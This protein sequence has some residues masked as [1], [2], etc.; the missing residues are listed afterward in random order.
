MAG[1]DQT[2]FRRLLGRF[3]TGVTVVTTQVGREVHG[4]TANAFTS[5]SLE[6]PLVLICVD[7]RAHMLELLRQSGAYC[8][9]FLGEHQAGVSDYFAKRPVP[10][11]EE[12]FLPW[13]CGPRLSSALASLA[14]RVESHHEAGDH[15]LFVG[16]V[17][18]LHE[19][20]GTAR[21]L[22]FFG[23]SYGDFHRRGVPGAA[24]SVPLG[25]ADQP[26][27]FDPG[28]VP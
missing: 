19:G 7:R 11:P 1:V 27:F 24:E 2:S 28:E 18:A 3:A 15:I 25:L 10:R 5:V 23:G 8:V 9:N 22:V 12:R 16:R 4:M 21:P 26:I 20:D 17:V 6:P 13:E 14:C